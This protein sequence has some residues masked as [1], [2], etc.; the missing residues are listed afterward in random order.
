MQRVY[1]E[2]PFGASRVIKK[3]KIWQ[4]ESLKYRVIDTMQL[5]LPS[6][7]SQVKGRG[8]ELPICMISDWMKAASRRHNLG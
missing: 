4:R 2:V 6:D 3:S 1:W 7:M 8:E 5:G